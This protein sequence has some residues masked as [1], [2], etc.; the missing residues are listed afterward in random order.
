MTT[1]VWL[2][3][4]P[5]HD[6]AFAILFAGY[7]PSLKLL[8]IST[9]GGN[10]EHE[11]VVRNASKVLK[12]S[13]LDHLRVY[14]G[15][16]KP[17]LQKLLVC[18]EIHG[19]SG[20]DTPINQS[21][22]LD[23]YYAPELIVRDHK[24]VI[25]LAQLLSTLDEPIH[26]IATGPL[27]NYA[28]L[29]TLYPELHSKIKRI[30]FMGGSIGVGNISPAAEFNILVDS[31]AASIVI[32]SGVPITMVPLEVTHKAI[33]TDQIMSLI[34]TRLNHSPFSTLMIDLL[35]FFKLT[36]DQ[37]FGF[38]QGPPLHDPCAVA[39]LVAPHLFT[40][41][42]MHVDV[43]TSDGLCKGRTVCDIYNLSIGPKIDVAID[44]DVDAFMDMLLD[45]LERADQHSPLNK[46]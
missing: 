8:G 29:L 41:Q 30:I 20:L 22:I 1:P 24:A 19:D 9:V 40:I 4:D 11:K 3:C 42:S 21:N 36:Y 35:S 13:G 12:V 26:L 10:Q 38:K 2:D 32:Q 7:Q 34:A 23:T 33:I 16:D 25:H 43:V 17:L 5:G 6:N 44:I 46:K 15:Q 27:T 18:P 37:V 39:F 14:P 31:E 28:L 45:T